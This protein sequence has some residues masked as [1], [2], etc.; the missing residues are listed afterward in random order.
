[1]TS[2]KPQCHNKMSSEKSAPFPLVSAYE[3]VT[4]P[5]KL[6]NLKNLAYHAKRLLNAN[7]IESLLKSFK[8]GRLESL[9]VALTVPVDLSP[10][11]FYKYL[12]E[13]LRF[14]ATQ[15]PDRELASAYYLRAIAMRTVRTA[16]LASLVKDLYGS[17]L[18]QS[19]KEHYPLAMQVPLLYMCIQAGHPIACSD[20]VLMGPA[21]LRHDVM[22]FYYMGL[23][24][25][26]RSEVE[27]ADQCMAKAWAL[28]SGAQDMRP[29]IIE[30]MS[31]TTF[32]SGRPIEVFRARL[33]QKFWPSD[34]AAAAIWSLTGH[35]KVLSPLYKQFESDIEAM[36]ARHVILGAARTM[37]SVKVKDLAQRAQITPE[38]RF[39]TIL[40]QMITDGVI[41]ATV[42][43]GVIT[44]MK[45]VLKIDEAMAKVAALAGQQQAK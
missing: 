45:I 5:E 20:P 23:N 16:T 40:Y 21:C 2:V 38:T 17:G 4:K 25:L 28:S 27:I 44:D 1:M 12:C 13:I 14:F 24:R 39:E 30:A 35:Q 31:L 42:A 43:D 10:E 29:A 9:A 22:V 26:F 15:V 32:L 41:T 6:E 37:T 34:N 3:S 11:P 33:K 19:L 18:I 7:N 36:H 8:P